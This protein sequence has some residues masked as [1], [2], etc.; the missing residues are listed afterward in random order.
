MRRFPV[1]ECWS[2]WQRGQHSARRVGDA[3]DD[4]D[5]GGSRSARGAPHQEEN[6]RRVLLMEQ[7]RCDRLPP[8]TPPLPFSGQ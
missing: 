8:S 3:F 5:P 4:R 6:R 2:V 1:V 7:V